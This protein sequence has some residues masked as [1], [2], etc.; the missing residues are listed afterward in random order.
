MQGSAMTRADNTA[1]GLIGQLSETWAAT[2][3]AC[4]SLTAAQWSAP[5]S[6]P[7]WSVKDQVVHMIGTESILA[8]RVAPDVAVAEAPH[9][10]NDIGRFNERWITARRDVDAPAVLEEFEAITDERLASLQSL[11]YEAWE[12]ATETPVGPASYRRF[13]QIRVFDSWVHEMD[14]KDALYPAAIPSAGAAAEQSLDEVERALGV[15]IGKRAGA[16]SGSR[17]TLSVTGPIKRTIHVAVSDRAAVVDQLDGPST[18]ILRT[19]SLTLLRIACGRVSPLAELAS[20]T[21]SIAGDTALGERI[22]AH[23]PFTI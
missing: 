13:M 15:L 4:R 3:V 17:V 20:Q 18:V 16:P 9:V 10:R 2:T 19:D 22:V 6:C 1:E 5:T 11:D 14:I 23:L 12:A 21:V 8:G 7:G